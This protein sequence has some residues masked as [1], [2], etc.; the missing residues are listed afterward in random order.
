[1]TKPAGG[2]SAGL[3]PPVRIDIKVDLNT[4]DETGLPWAYLDQ[5]PDP[6]RIIP[7]T[8]VV[9]GWG[10][11]AAVAEIVDVADDGVVHLRPLRGQ[12]SAHAHLLAPPAGPNGP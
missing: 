12:V 10:T 4:E 11:V 7:G 8:Y 2:D 1:M 3:P 6:S 9:A 5:A